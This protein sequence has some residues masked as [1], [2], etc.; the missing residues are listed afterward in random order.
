MERSDF[1]ERGELK[2]DFLKYYRLVS[3]WAARNNDLNIADL[4]LLFYLDPILYFTIN[5]FKDGTL[6]YSWDKER[7]YRLQREGWIDKTHKGVGRRGDHNKY[8]VS[9]KGKLLINKIY[10]ILIDKE[11]IPS[12]ARRNTIMKRKTYIDKV[13]SQA[14]K[15]FNK[16]KI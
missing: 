9:Q 16:Q 3:R 7:F 1:I 13:Y 4:E 2:V 14:I 8:K 11:E 10:R 12:S 15:K 5:D 6:F